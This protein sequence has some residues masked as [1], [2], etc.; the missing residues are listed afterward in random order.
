MSS[1]IDYDVA[2]PA[3]LPARSSQGIVLGLDPW[4]VTTLLIAAASILLSVQRFGPAGLLYAAPIYLPFGVGAV[5]RT[6]G[7]SLPRWIAVWLNKA[8]RDATGANRE[9]FAP[10][11]VRAAGTLRLPGRLGAL[12]L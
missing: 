8:F 11:K 4:Q 6:R 12:E 7:M 1:N 9:V 3:R 10:E 2:R 5:V